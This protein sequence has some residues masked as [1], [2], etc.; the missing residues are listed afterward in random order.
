MLFYAMLKSNVKLNNVK[1]AA[2]YLRAQYGH[3]LA[4][5]VASAANVARN[6][7]KRFTGKKEDCTPY[8]VCKKD[9][10]MCKIVPNP[11]V[12]NMLSREAEN[13]LKKLCINHGI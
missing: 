7:E 3:V 6:V 1:K 9:G 13:V 8:R 5:K 4:T 12:D 2:G 10:Q 11:T